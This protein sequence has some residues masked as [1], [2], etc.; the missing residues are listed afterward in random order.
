MEYGISN[1]PLSI[2][3]DIYPTAMCSRTM[4]PDKHTKQPSTNK[5]PESQRHGDEEEGN[6]TIALP[7]ELEQK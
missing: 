4:Q 3:F 5:G 1:V 7:L 2:I 6:Q